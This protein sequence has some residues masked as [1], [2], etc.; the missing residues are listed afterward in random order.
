[1]KKLLSFLLALCL[2]CACGLAAAEEDPVLVTV[3]GEE[4]RES[5][6]WLQVWEEDLLDQVGGEAD[7]ETM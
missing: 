4:I 6:L 1:M 2:L 7:E 3:D 5:S